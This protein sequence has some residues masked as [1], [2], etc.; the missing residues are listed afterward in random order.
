MPELWLVSMGTVGSLLKCYIESQYNVFVCEYLP[1]LEY[2]KPKRNV[3]LILIISPVFEQDVFG[4][5][6]KQVINAPIVWFCQDSFNETK[7]DPSVVKYRCDDTDEWV[8][9]N[10][11]L[12]KYLAL[13]VKKF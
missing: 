12:A 3:A 1:A 5:I 6:H 10:N 2:N 4:A 9:F 11:V 7:P 8:L 13:F